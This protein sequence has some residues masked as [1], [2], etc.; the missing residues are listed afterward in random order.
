MLSLSA[1]VF[2]IICQFFFV[3]F[4][5]DSHVNCGGPPERKAGNCC[6]SK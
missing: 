2:L 1:M 6:K 4:S 3:M 5:Q